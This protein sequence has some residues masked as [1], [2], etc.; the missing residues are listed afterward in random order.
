MPLPESPVPIRCAWL[1]QTCAGSI[2]SQAAATSSCFARRGGSAARQGFHSPCSG[3]SRQAAKP[4]APSAPP[5][6]PRTTFL[7]GPILDVA[8]EHLVLEVLL[9]QDC[10]G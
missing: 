2:P 1:S 8:L 3:H 6:R 5:R 10:L 9:F 4:V 7:R